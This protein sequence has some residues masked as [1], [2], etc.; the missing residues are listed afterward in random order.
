M[1]QTITVD[2][3]LTDAL[4]AKYIVPEVATYTTLNVTSE[5]AVENLAITLSP[6]CSGAI[7]TDNACIKS[8]ISITAGST[9]SWLR[10]L[11]LTGFNF[12]VITEPWAMRVTIESVEM[13]RDNGSDITA[14]LPMDI[15]IQGTQNLV[16]DCSSYGSDKAI[17]FPVVVQSLTAG[18]NAVLNHYSQLGD[19]TISPHQR[20]AHGFLIENSDVSIALENRRYY[21]TGQGWAINAGVGWNIDAS[22]IEVESPPLGINWCVGCKGTK[23]LEGNGTFVQEG[24]SVQPESLY[25]SQ[26]NARGVH[27]SE[28]QSLLRSFH[29]VF[30]IA[31]ITQCA[32]FM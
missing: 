27:R 10:N 32:L 30:A 14:G 31:L 18:P 9:D 15:T 28:S 5:M 11:K 24:N 2:I 6:T 1:D 3:P 29:G 13:Y 8:A 23:S 21:G 22:N 19:N 26:L 25:W 4:D 7:L 12:F 17:A 16:N 20:W